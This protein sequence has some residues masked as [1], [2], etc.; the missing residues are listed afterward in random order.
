MPDPTTS[1]RFLTVEPSDGHYESFYLKACPP[2]GGQGLW[3][4]HTVHKRPGAEPTASVWF[5]F[6]DA[7]S[8]GPVASKGTQPASALSAPEGGYI[9]VGDST[10]TPSHAAGALRTRSLDAEWDLS[11]DGSDAPLHHLPSSWMYRAPV[12][13]TKLMS[14]HP[15]A[16]FT[17]RVRIGDRRLDVSGWRGMVGHNWG[18]EHAERWIWMHGT[19]FADRPQDTWFD[20]SAGRIA[21]GPVT[22]PWVANGV[23]CLDGR[24]HRLGGVGRTRSTEISE[25]PGG[26]RFAFAG[27]GVSVR[28]TATASR[29]DTVA[30]RYA[31]PDGSEHHVLNCSIS[32]LELYVERRGEPATTLVVARGAAFEL[33]MRETDHGIVV[34]PEADGGS[35]AR[36]RAVRSGR[37]ASG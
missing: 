17:G 21:L 3:I 22:S 9:T 26:A 8:G 12:P 28:G 30:W 25:G 6:F 15:G 13:R 10:L 11:I 33:G 36:D 20:M 29:K 31:D 7:E 34:Q 37:D 2:G 4:R 1:A 23:L 19:A 5:T 24:R 18:A 32:N 14:P 27:R 16:T 35:A